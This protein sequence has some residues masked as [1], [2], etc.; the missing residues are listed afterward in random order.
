MAQVLS[1]K[2]HFVNIERD[3][4]AMGM[5]EKEAD[6]LR[7]TIY[8]MEKHAAPVWLHLVEMLDTGKFSTLRQETNK[9]RFLTA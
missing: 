9:A 8:S 4:Q 2:Q 3:F 6:A 1:T 7:A 5:P